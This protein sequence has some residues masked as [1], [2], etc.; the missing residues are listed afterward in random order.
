MNDRMLRGA[1]GGAALGSLLGGGIAWLVGIV[2]LG[3]E[4]AIFL[5]CGVYAG[6]VYG[7]IV[8]AVRAARHSPELAPARL[9]R[10]PR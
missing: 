9:S 1:F 10:A 2:M 4:P 3:L 5:A 7:V 6:T 8:G